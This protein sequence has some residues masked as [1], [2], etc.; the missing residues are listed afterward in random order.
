M[1]L[2]TPLLAYARANRSRFVAELEDFVRFPSVSAAKD[3]GVT[4]SIWFLAQVG[5]MLRRSGQREKL[6]LGPM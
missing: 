5:A 3:R 6:A 2:A 4:T 1:Q